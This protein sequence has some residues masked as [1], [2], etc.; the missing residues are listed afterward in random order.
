MRIN[1]VVGSYLDP[2]ADK[3][4]VQASSSELDSFGGLLLSG[5]IW[6]ILPALQLNFVFLMSG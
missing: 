5:C 2:L 3:V 1:S 4:K 6:F